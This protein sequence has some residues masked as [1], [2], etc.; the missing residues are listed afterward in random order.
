[1]PTD[2]F[3]YTRIFPAPQPG[4]TADTLTGL[5]PAPPTAGNSDQGITLSFPT[6]IHPAQPSRNIYPDVEALRVP[7]SLVL[8][9]FST[10]GDRNS[11]GGGEVR[12]FAPLANGGYST[13]GVLIP[14][15]VAYGD[16]GL[17]VHLY[18][19]S[20]APIHLVFTPVTPFSSSSLWRPGHQIRIDLSK[21]LTTTF[22]DV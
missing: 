1:M 13:T 16:Y 7:G 2:T 21:T 12:S 19:V 3:T 5:V 18:E 6:K 10:P 14:V 9:G 8:K 17:P 11:G 4:D 20:G 22:A 15:T